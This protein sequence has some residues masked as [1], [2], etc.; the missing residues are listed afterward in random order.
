[1]K[2]TPIIGLETHV[3]LK[4]KSKMFCSCDN[5]GE[6]QKPNTTVCPVCMGHPGVL[7]VA[8]KKAV[9]WSVMASLAINCQI[10]EVSKFDRKSYFYPDLPKAYQISQFDQ[11]IGQK[12]F[13]E[14]QT[15]D[16]SR[17]INITRLH[18]EEDA[19][20]SYHS[21]DGKH[22][23]VDYNR[24]STPLMEIV[25][26]PDIRTPA[27]AKAYLQE[28]KL[29]MRYLGV[30][31]A[32]MEKG[33]LRCDANISLTDQDPDNIDTKKLSPKT[34]IKNLNSFKAVERALEYEIKR[35]T[36]LWQEGQVPQTETTRGWDEDKG[37]TEEQ[38]GKEGA[39][40]YRYFPDP[41][42]P[43][44][45]FNP[46]APNAIDVEKIKNSLPELP[47]NKRQRFMDEYGLS[48]ENA[49]I[50]TDDKNLAEFFEQVISELQAWLI[51]LD[52]EGTKEEIWENNKVKLTKIAANWL[53]NKLMPIATISDSTFVNITAENFAEFITLIY[54]NKINSTIGQKL[55]EK[56]NDS[57]K[58]PSNILEEEGFSQDQNAEEL[59]KIIEKIV[60]DNPAQ[61]EQYKSG[62]EAVFQYFVGQVMKETKGSA[63]PNTTKDI[64][65]NKLK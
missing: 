52:L 25:S 43:P 51:T 35:Q 39:A 41:D 14:I 36:K 63:D 42:L 44:I 11:P 2:L 62:K 20:K 9:E 47:Q 49:K 29:I 30:S 12:G 27:E 26:E 59:G 3:Q 10:P 57:G 37:I 38:R 32:D 40:D 21:K 17:K 64:L 31:D 45:N 55:L 28:L 8:N 54:Q 33:H 7:P 16:G 24:S 1:M 5:T 60:L 50:I 13:L 48:A 58:D 19:A 23:L 61:V 15:K 18:L 53:I 4:T 56:M 22:T 46:S 6:D 34:E 65:I